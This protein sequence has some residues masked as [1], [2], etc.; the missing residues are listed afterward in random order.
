MT[1]TKKKRRSRS[2]GAG[3]TAA[4]ATAAVVGLSGCGTQAGPAATATASAAGPASTAVG[5]G[6]AAAATRQVGTCEDGTSSSA[7]FYAPRIQAMLA[8]AVAGWVPKP[9]A[10]TGNGIAAQPGLHFVLRSVTTT[11]V[12]T[13]YPSVDATIPAVG[14][15]SPQPS[16]TDSSFN[17]DVHTWTDQESG[18][19]HS[20]DQATAA[21]ATLAGQV[22]T[23]QV[24]RNTYSAIYACIAA[25][26][27][28]LGTA[29]GSDTR[30]AVVSD[31]E[32][33]EPEPVTGFGLNG[34]AVLVVGICPADVSASCSQRFATG[35]QFL[36]QH[37]ASLVQVVWADAVTAQT[38]ETFWRS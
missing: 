24:A 26:V 33:N 37:G 1:Q 22:R 29:H 14:A 27:N 35:R 30:I 15:L 12:S 21:A 20:A 3:V 6:S 9:P 8:Q 28:Q 5:S 31:M 2:G 23:Y 36:I 34:A 38:F 10:D 18:W 25:V 11:S 4:V 7:I 17:S 13:D 16:P 19:K 32:N